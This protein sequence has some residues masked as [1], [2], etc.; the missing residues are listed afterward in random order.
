MSVVKRM[1]NVF[2]ACFLL[3]GICF[4]QMEQR[5]FAAA[6]PEDFGF[7]ATI[8]KI[9]GRIHLLGL[10]PGLITDTQ[11]SFTSARIYGL[12]L[13][14]FV[15]TERGLMALTMK[16]NSP[17]SRVDAHWLQVKV[18]ALNIGGLCLPERLLDVCLTDLTI[19]GKGLE[20]SG[21]EIPNLV[22][23]T[24]FES[25]EIASIQ[26]LQTLLDEQG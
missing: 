26:K 5:A 15:R 6:E 25:S 11:V 20:S 13:S 9:S 7:I 24:S 1:K 16:T 17:D 21:I 3:F 4:P 23:E 18:N 2:M 10:R 12:T 19:D 14:K 8:D 22:V